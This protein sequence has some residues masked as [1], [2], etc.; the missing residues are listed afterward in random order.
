MGKRKN[1]QGEGKEIAEDGL[2]AEHQEED[3]G[4]DYSGTQQP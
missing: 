1:V 2:N 4:E 3:A